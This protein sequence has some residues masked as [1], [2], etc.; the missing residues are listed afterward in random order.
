MT[1]FFGF[2]F[3]LVAVLQRF[4]CLRSDL[5]NHDFYGVGIYLLTML[6]VGSVSACSFGFG[7]RCFRTRPEWKFQRVRICLM[8]L[9]MGGAIM[10][11]VVQ[12]V[13]LFLFVK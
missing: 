12:W 5:E 11:I 7:L 6:F 2:F 8:Y 1:L 3:L 10:L 9:L 13:I 4:E